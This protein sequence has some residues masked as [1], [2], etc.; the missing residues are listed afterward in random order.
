MREGDDAIW[1]K[2]V[3][4]R[5]SHSKSKVVP[6]SEKSNSIGMLRRGKIYRYNT[7]RINRT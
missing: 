4:Y 2:Q 7:G 1:K 3:E 5:F 6:V